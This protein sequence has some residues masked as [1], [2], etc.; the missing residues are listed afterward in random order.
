MKKIKNKFLSKMPFFRAIFFEMIIYTQKTFARK[1]GVFLKG[2]Q[3]IIFQPD[4]SDFY[5]ASIFK[6]IN[7]K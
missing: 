5:F 1:F 3:A 6:K 7:K 2:F 4:I